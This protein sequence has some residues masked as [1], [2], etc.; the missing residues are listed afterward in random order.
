[1]SKIILGCMAFGAPE[2]IPWALE[3]KEAIEQI[4]FA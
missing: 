3:E 1:V 2:A 4:K